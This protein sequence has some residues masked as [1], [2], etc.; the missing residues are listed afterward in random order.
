LVIASVVV[1]HGHRLQDGCRAAEMSQAPGH[2][3]SL[4]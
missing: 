3:E 2:V 1:E 4:I